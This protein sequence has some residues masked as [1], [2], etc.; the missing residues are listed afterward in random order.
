MDTHSLND[1]SVTVL[2]KELDLTQKSK[3]P[4]AKGEVENYDIFGLTE[5]S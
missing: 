3:I 5:W 4:A 1:S 2:L